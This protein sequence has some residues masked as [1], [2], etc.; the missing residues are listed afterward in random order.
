MA[1]ADTTILEGLETPD[2]LRLLPEGEL[3]RV[4]DAVR[5]EMIDAV[6]IT[7][8]HLGSGL[9]VVELTVALHHVF[10][11]P[12]DRIV[13][14]VGHQCYPH[15][16]LTGRRDRI[17][18]LRQG[19]G[20]SG[21]TKRSESAYDPFGAAHSSTSIS[22]ALG[23]AVARDLDAAQ[24]KAR[25]EAQPK[26][27]NMV[28]VIGDGSMSA[29]MAYEAMNNAGALHSRLIVILN[30]NDMSI[31]P[32]VGAMSA[33][34]A[35][36]ASGG[37]YRSL[38]ETAKQL[39][40]LLPKALYQRAAAAEE[41]ARSLIVGGGTMFEEMGFHYVGPVDGHN[42]DHLL[43]VLKNVRDSDQGPILL[44]VVTRKGKGYAPAEASADRYHGV[45]RFDV[46]SGIQAKAKANAPAYTRVFGE[47]LIKAADADPKVV[48]ITAAMPGGT[49]IDLFGK[50]HPD[51]TFD[52]GIAEQHAV[53]FAGGLAT[54]G[55]KPFVAI[56][57]TFLQRAYDQVVH[58][59]ALQNL[60]VR[61]CLD[62]AGLV[63]AD[64][65][66]HAGAFDLAYLCCLPN[67]T[68]MAAADEAELV[69]MVATAHAHDAGP[70]ALRYPRGEGVG[71]ELP[72][73]GEP[74]AIGRGRVVRRPEG[75][76]VALLSLGTRLSEALKAADA[77][78]AE[79]VAASVADA[80]FAKPL[81]AELIVDLANSHEVLVTVEEG[82]VGG[83][84][85]QVLHLLSERGV[86][87]AGRVRVRTLTLPDAYQDHDKPERMYAEAGLDADGIRNAVRDAMPEKPAQREGSVVSLKR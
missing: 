24:A 78:E 10:D 28:A 15:K 14:D 71:V 86:L 11:T 8:G 80:R 69:H 25:G 49:G 72:E 23:M 66:T 60:P 81:D 75:A 6:S 83:F 30:D 9:G 68:V 53:T 7:G 27:R 47:S 18:T 20:L 52:V 77:L 56:Y 70:I 61:F 43:P 37:T 39:G 64:G 2:R 51:R 17:R 12:D 84:G 33:Y 50:A 16:I 21:F 35:R 48:A 38:R 19:G 82:S 58:D 4:A 42:L 34:L 29:G 13:W 31:A 26:R 32:P 55:C 44:H 45:V 40:K 63:G 1:L 46:V 59:V 36:L 62:R 85:A 3:Q 87:D 79:G 74:L 76:R 57:S 41:Y 73:R 67:M 22:A 54:E 5:A 65:A